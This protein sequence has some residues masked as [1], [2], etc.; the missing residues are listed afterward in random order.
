MLLAAYAPA[1]G[2]SLWFFDGFETQIGLLVLLVFVATCI[3]W[4]ARRQ[5]YASRMDGGRSRGRPGWAD[6]HWRARVKALEEREP[7]AIASATAGPVRIVATIASAPQTLGG[8][9]G[10]ECVWRN[11]PGAGP[12]TAIAVE[13]VFV[14]DASGRCAIDGLEHARVIAPIERPPGVSKVR[15]ASTRREHVALY[16]GDVVEIFGRFAPERVGDDPDPTKLVYGTLGG[17]G[18]LE[19]HLRTRVSVSPTPPSD[20]TAPVS[21]DAP[22]APADAASDEGVPP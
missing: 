9:P 5:A 14:A 10:R 12:E 21:T 8:E 17:A 19:I 7:T 4:L 16:V 18:P 6:P 3:V 15:V 13:L 22:P 2:D 11:Q 20:E 1:G